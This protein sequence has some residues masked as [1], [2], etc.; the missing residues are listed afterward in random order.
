MTDKRKI[1]GWI[2]SFLLAMTLFSAAY[3][4]SPEEAKDIQAKSALSMEKL[5]VNREAGKDVFHIVP[6]MK[7]VKVLGDKGKFKE[8]NR[9]LDKI[10][11]EFQ[12]LNRPQSPDVSSARKAQLFHN[13]RKVNIIGYGQSVMEISILSQRCSIIRPTDFRRFTVAGFKMAG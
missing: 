9:L 3:A 11:Y 1:A 4:I 7:N 10:L 13:P 8:V 5:K 2:I 12:V 6:M